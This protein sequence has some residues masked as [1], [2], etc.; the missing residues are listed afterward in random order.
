MQFR[1]LFLLKVTA[2]SHHK[3]TLDRQVKVRE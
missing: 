2:R 1:R 3:V